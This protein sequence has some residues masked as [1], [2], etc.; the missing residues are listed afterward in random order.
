MREMLAE[1]PVLVEQRHAGRGVGVQHLLGGN[2]LDLVGIDIKPELGSRDLLTGIVNMLQFL[3][4]PVC[5]LKQ[6]LGCRVHG[7]AF[8]FW[9]RWNSSGNT[10]KISLGSLTLRIDSGAPS[11]RNR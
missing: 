6:A 1:R 2:D 3:E 7:A 5:S 9:R 11:A 10:R 4:I 8:S